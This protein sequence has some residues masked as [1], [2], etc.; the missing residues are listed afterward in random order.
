MDTIGVGLPMF[1]WYG[2]NQDAPGSLLERIQGLLGPLRFTRGN[3]QDN[4][5]TQQGPSGAAGQDERPDTAQGDQQ[6]GQQ[7]EQVINCVWLKQS[8]L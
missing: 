7:Q 4:N 5:D 1:Y 8:I 3:R 6:A 2:T